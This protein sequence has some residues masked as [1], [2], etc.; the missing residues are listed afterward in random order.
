MRGLEDL[1]IWQE[2]DLRRKLLWYRQVSAN[3]MP[4]KFRIAGHIP[5]KV[6]LAEAPEETLWEELEAKTPAFLDLWDRIRRGMADLPASPRPQP[7][8]VG[9]CRE[10]CIRMLTHCNFCRWNCR[11]DRRHG[12]KLG[13]CKLAEDSRV[14]S[15]F[16]HPGEELIY[17][18]RLGSGT[19]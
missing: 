7:N 18:G 16:H 1:W 19:I 2:E 9:L 13:T 11:V 10:L 17:R 8:L 5:V 6:P 3:R 14:S 12:T 15:Y 4:A